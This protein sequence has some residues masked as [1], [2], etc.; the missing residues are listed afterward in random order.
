MVL[1]KII[2]DSK[3]MGHLAIERKKIKQAGAKVEFK[4]FTSTCKVRV[5]GSDESVSLALTLVTDGRMLWL[6]SKYERKL[7]FN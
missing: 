1:G 4:H 5:V 2:F 6:C 7:T 3:V